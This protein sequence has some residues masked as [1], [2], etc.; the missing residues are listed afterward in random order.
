[1]EELLNA[2]AYPVDPLEVER[3]YTTGKY[4]TGFL[5]LRQPREKWDAF[6]ARLLAGDPA[7]PVLLETY[8]WNDIGALE[9]AFTQFVR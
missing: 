9:K 4:L 8:G 3:F 6:F 1:M 5:L 7:L 2:T